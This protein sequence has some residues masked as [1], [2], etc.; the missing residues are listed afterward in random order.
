MLVPTD[1]K[2]EIIY[3]VIY[4]ALCLGIVDKQSRGQYLDIIQNLTPRD[5]QEIILGCTEISSLVDKSHT[6]NTLYDTTFIHTLAAVEK[7]L[8]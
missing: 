5:A 7:D 4:Q 2:Q 3:R 1:D 8:K 6:K